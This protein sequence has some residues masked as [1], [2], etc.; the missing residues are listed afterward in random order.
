MVVPDQHTLGVRNLLSMEGLMVVMVVMVDLLS[1][2][3]I[4]I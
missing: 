1:L 4:V 2:S 3:L